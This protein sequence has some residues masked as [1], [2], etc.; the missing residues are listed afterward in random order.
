MQLQGIG[1]FSVAGRIKVQEIKLQTLQT[2]NVF[3]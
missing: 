3:C 2:L 1:L